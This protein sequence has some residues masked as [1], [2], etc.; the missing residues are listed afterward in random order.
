M[1]DGVRHVPIVA[2]E[3]VHPAYHQSVPFT[4]HIKEALAFWS[5]LH[6]DAYARYALIGHDFVNDEPGCFCLCP[7]VGCILVF[8]RYTGVKD[9]LHVGVPLCVH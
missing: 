9:G 8:G 4:E 1:L 3:P 5:L 2:P 6:R 7:L